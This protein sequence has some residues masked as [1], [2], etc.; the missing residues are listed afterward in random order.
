MGHPISSW[1]INWGDGTAVQVVSGNP[2]QVAH[3]YADGTIVRA[4]S[5]TATDDLGTDNAGNTLNVSVNN[6]APTVTI[7]GASSVNRDSVYTLFLAKIDPGSHT[8]SKWIIKWGDGS[9]PQTV[10]GSPLS[11]THTFP[12][13]GSLVI[14]ATAMDED[15]TYA[16]NSLTLNVN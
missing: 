3:T 15:G 14:S 2:S 4:I 8:I 9:A 1:A 11:V 12:L 6:V 7:S 13:A 16:A 5:A 10:I